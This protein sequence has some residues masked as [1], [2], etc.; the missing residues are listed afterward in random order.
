MSRA[1]IGIFLF[2][3]FCLLFLSEYA[4]AFRLQEQDT[5]QQDTL[6]NRFQGPYEPTRRPTYEQKDRFGDPFSNNTSP[7]PLLLQDPANLKMDV[8]IDTGMNY[9]IYEK[10]GD[11][12]YRPTTTMSFE[13]FNRYA[14]QQLVRNYWKEKSIGLDG[15]SAVSGR[16]LIPKLFI[17]PV[18]DRIFGGS[19][20]D[21]QPNGFV[22]LDFGARFQRIDNP[23]VPVR[24]QR[25]GGFEFDQQISMNVLGKI[26]EKLAVT[27]NFD[28]NNSFDFQNNLKVEY[29]GYEEDIIKKIEIGNVSMPI[30]NSL[31]TGGQSLFGVK[32]QLQ[33]GKLFVTGIAS[34]QQG[35]NEVI[36]VESGFQGREFEVRASNYDEN[37]HF[38]LGHFFRNNYERWLAGLP[39]ILSGINITRVEVYILN[40]NNDTQTLRNVVGLMDL[41]EGQRIFR[42]DNPNIGAGNS[43]EASN[44]A[45]N[46]YNSLV[47]TPGIRDVDQVSGLLEGNAFN[48]E[49]TVDFERVTAARK[50]DQREY[51]VNTQLGYVS[52]LRRLQ[53]DE[54]LAVSYEYTFNGRR[55]KVGELTEDYANRPEDEVI[56][57]KMLRPTQINTRVPTWDLMMKNVYNLGANQVERDGFTLRIHYRDDLT[58][59]D[60]P[61]LHQGARTQ[62]QQLIRLLRLDQLN[63][64]NDPQ[65]DGNFDF[66]EGVTIDTRNG[67]IIFPVLEPFGATLESFFDPNTELNLIDRFVY[68]TLYRTTKADAELVASQNKYFILGRLNAGSSNEIVLPGINIAE[69]SVVVTA[70]NTPL[71]EGLDYTVD[72]NLGKVRIINESILN[73]GRQIDIAY[74]KA[75]LF[76]FQ[77]RWLTGTRLDYRL[78]ENVNFGATVLHLNERPGGISRF[79]VGNEPTKNTKYGFD[80]NV[81]E[82]SRLLTKMIDA[83]PMITTKE[84]S[85]VTFSGE[86]AQI[87]PGTSNIVD[88]KGTSYI[89]D[90]EA[91]ATPFNLGG[92]GSVLRWKLAATP[93]TDDGRFDLTAQAGSPVG[94]AFRR[95]KIAW[96]S[97]DN[98]FYRGG[99]PNSPDNIEQEDLENNYIR[100]V[101][102]QEIFQGQDQQVLNTN[103]PIFDIAYFPEER[104]QY[105]YNPNLNPDGTLPDPE[106]NWGGMTQ[107][108]TADVD[109]DKTNIEYIEF[110]LMD[111]FTSD[112]ADLFG[113]NVQEG[114]QGGELY[115]NLGNISE[116]VMKDGR[117]AFEQGLPTDTNS[118]DVITNEWGRV[119]NKQYLTEFFDNS[120]NALENQDVG[121]D[122][123]RN[124]QEAQFFEGSYLN[125]LNISGPI[126]DQIFEDPS[127]DNFIHYLDPI[128]Q[129]GEQDN[130][131]IDRYKNWNGMDQNSQTRGGQNFTTSGT[132]LPDN[133]DLNNDNSITDLESY[134]EYRIPLRPQD[135]EVGR[136]NIVDVQSTPESD[137]RWF[138]F[139]IPVRNP[140]RIQ[141]T[142]DGFKSIRYMRTYLTGFRD[143]VVLR[144]AK[145]QL[146]GSQW[147]KFTENLFQKGFNEL[148]EESTSDF[149]VSVVNIEENGGGSERS[150]PYVLPPGINRD[151][152]NT[153]P[154][155][156]RINEQSLQIC[157]DELD[158]RD[159]RAVYKNVDLDLINYGKLQMFFHAEG[160]NLQN[161]E[162]TGFLRL[163]TDFVENYY[164][165][166][167]PLE[168]SPF[169]NRDDFAENEI[170]RIV[171][172]EANE[173]DV[174]IDDLL[175]LK[176]RRNRL[177]VDQELLFVDTVDNQR[178][179]VR[180]N[181]DISTVQVLMIGVRNPETEDQATKS[182]CLWANELRVTDFNRRAGYAANGRL[183]I[184]LADFANVTTSGRYVSNDFGGIQQRIAERTREETT[185]YDVSSTINVD[186]LIPGNHGIKIPMFVSYEKSVATPKFDPTDPD[187]PLENSIDAFTNREEGEEFKKIVQDRSERRSIN[188]TN[189]RKEKVNPEAKSRIY[190]IE[191][192]TFSYSFSELTRSNV[193]TESQ[194][195]R[196]YS[197]GL[198]YNYSPSDFTIEPFKNVGFL[199]NPFLKLIKDFN[200][201]PVPSNLG[202]R[203]DLDRRF[204]RTQLRNGD[205]S[206]DG[207]DP[208]FEKL[209][210]FN[211]LYNLRWNLTRS[212]SL[213]YSARVNA[214]VDE[215]NEIDEEGNLLTKEERR[216]S[217]YNSLKHL[218]RTKNF[219]QNITATYRLPLD[220]F[221]IT[222]WTSAD[223]RYSASYT[224]DAGSIQQADTLGNTISNSRERGANGKVDLVKLYNKIKFLKDINTPSRRR[225]S[226][227]R[228]PTT[229]DT[230]KAGTPG[231]VKGFL[232]LL[233]SVRSVN[234]NYSIREGTTLPGFRP[235]TFLFGLDSA[236]DAPGA[237][238]IFGS[239][240]PDIRREAARNGWL[241]RSTSLTTPFIQSKTT[242][243]NLRAQIEPMRDFRIQLDA[244]KTVTGNFQEIFRFDPAADPNVDNG[245]TSLTPA[246]SGSYSISFFSIRTA[247]QRQD[248]S[249]NTSAFRNFEA[250]REIIRSRLQTVNPSGEYGPNSQD[251][252]IPA[253]IAAYSDV[254]PDEISLNP[255]PRTPIPNWRVDY[256]GL[257]RIPALSEIFSSINITHSYSSTFSVG[258]FTN[259]LLYEPE[260]NLGNLELTNNITN[261]PFA[262]RTNEDGELVPFYIINDVSISERFAPLIGLNIRTKTRLTARIEYRKERNLA[263]QLSNSQISEMRSNDFSIDFGWTKSDWK[264]PFRVQGRTVTLKNDITFRMNFTIR[265]TETIQRRI[266]EDPTVTQ[267]NINFQ[268]R[269]TISYIVNERLNI[270]AFFERT[271][272]EPRVT[273]SFK[274]A[275][276]AAGVQLRF[277]LS[278]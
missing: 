53:N 29:T 79:S 82:E 229:N 211:R 257:S 111:P 159:S 34:R 139:R 112:R 102:P 183:N 38:F 99:G 104:G 177:N 200:F 73:S 45:N 107:G 50:L 92:S 110:W 77:T 263:L 160:Q 6:R 243:L 22:N 216:D 240:D 127:G 174:S 13:E 194:V 117:H 74:E 129:A 271:I 246:R 61:S 80:V 278:Q 162:V 32:A 228:Q 44:E 75:D 196:N 130:Q 193:N 3:T 19:Y 81:T 244:K 190:D 230:T 222:D 168:V 132:N 198:G 96:Y 37:R 23:A 41:G 21:I 202:F 12:N 51:V 179:T 201:S 220:K 199:D 242:D 57:M 273:N 122:G 153:S 2:V 150:S 5:T 167:I 249:R 126:R 105:N 36:S 264:I 109:F 90:F 258:N 144:M 66:I 261:Y 189:V 124:D 170:R 33:F 165:I 219:N 142:I 118:L 60:N 250:Y 276:T 137:A 277:S 158:D 54:V 93:E 67:N 120:D 76:N 26:G 252:L 171:W 16:Q 143:P 176:A 69:G 84:K 255:F 275:S 72:Y 221:P 208:F 43:P 103:L 225:P 236:F 166:E 253:F 70:G 251:V 156:R 115:F 218:G 217:I 164:E 241:A 151:R 83:V 113:L 172:P 62:D 49:R 184:Q 274:R 141:G 101:V 78:N 131:I 266:E 30:A 188:F 1:R 206:T 181:P 88:G 186:K 119:T 91:A 203:A 98:V 169:G 265:D 140:S 210:T 65:P 125:Q 197:G 87:L 173:I 40:R 128:H 245:F 100:Q 259:S 64:N 238:F 134:Y 185:E 237:G 152:D 147:R 4:R 232:R 71:T 52:L 135:L 9:T 270:Q 175:S 58:G 46:L 86:F 215:P 260:E 256:A 8:E 7:S 191:N 106:R 136:N 163:G 138:L 11:I 56:I 212:L 223:I 145:F 195:Q 47:N 209:F 227:G 148:P 213:D 248:T 42:P 235:R 59:V 28:N 268:L 116:D 204:T 192:F 133:E 226:R 17:S 97:I 94:N 247:F 182:V 262:T 14:D 233:M 39:Q 269:P 35:R 114:Q 63:P 89:D 27:A 157:V 123:L 207:I 20:V 149:L 25:N 187:T 254:D 31:I 239:Q 180:G 224:W 234:V 108:L 121:L 24:Q 267:G 55:F 10:I 161:E 18:F 68:D 214:I 178:I 15:E 85:T 231:A 146:V 48:L 272:N 154:I 95:A 205:L 155:F